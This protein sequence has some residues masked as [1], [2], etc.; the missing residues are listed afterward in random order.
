MN[1]K[2]GGPKNKIEQNNHLNGDHES[3]IMKQK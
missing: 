1:R 2:R 3:Q